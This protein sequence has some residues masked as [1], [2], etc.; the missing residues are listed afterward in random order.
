MNKLNML[1]EI[2]KGSSNKFEFNDYS[3]KW[4]LDRV[5]YGS[6]SYP[7]EYGF[8]PNTIDYDGDPLDVVCLINYP[9]FPGCSIPIRV[10]GVLRMI[11]QGEKDYKLI[12]V[13]DAD[14]RFKH[15]NQLEDIGIGKLEEIS[16]FFLRYKELEKKDVIINGYGNKEEAHS[17]LEECYELFEDC[18][19]LF[20]NK[21]NKNE[22]TKFL[23][24]RKK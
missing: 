2:N 9:T 5:L 20:H 6:M 4:E 10:I 21:A 24:E 13:N 1:V 12:A 23:K 16:N 11:D 22:I 18:K 15:I 8:I 14:S 7:E 3:K 17:I 19:E